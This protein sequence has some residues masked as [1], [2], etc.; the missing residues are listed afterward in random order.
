[1]TGQSNK[2]KPRG[3]NVGNLAGQTGGT[4]DGKAG[5]K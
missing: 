4:G 3:R 2:S 5:L 1:M